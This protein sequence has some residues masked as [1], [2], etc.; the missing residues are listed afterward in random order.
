[1]TATLDAISPFFVVSDTPLAI[2]FY[3]DRLG[4]AVA[5]SDPEDEPFTAILRR[6]NVQLFVKSESGIA[7]APNSSR[8]PHL[9]WDAFVYVEDPDALA[10][11][12][13]GRD[14]PLSKLLQD[15]S[16]GL[17]GFEVTDPDGYVLFFGRP[18]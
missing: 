11:E 4:F 13:A 15:T 14:A 3:R 18:R 12:F 6:D 10:E 16:D 1:M 17:R 8:H 2:A 5:W 9:R 7:P